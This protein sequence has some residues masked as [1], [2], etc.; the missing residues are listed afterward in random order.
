M[1]KDH[2]YEH[3]DQEAVE[4]RQAGE[5][6]EMAEAGRGARIVAL[7]VGDVNADGVLDS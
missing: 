1:L 2:L 3:R 5:F 7:A 6:R 4:N